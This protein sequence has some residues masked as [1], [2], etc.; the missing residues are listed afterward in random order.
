MK[1]ILIII[2]STFL[3]YS[4]AQCIVDAGPDIYVCVDK[5]G[6][7]DSSVLQASLL[8]STPYQTIKW[9]A[10]HFFGL[11][12]IPYL[13][14]SHFLDDTILF[15]PKIIFS[16]GVGNNLLL[17]F[18]I[19]LTDSLGNICI[20]STK[21]YFSK[22]AIIPDNYVEINEQ[23][24]IGL[25]SG[26]GGGIPPL[27]TIWTPNYNISD[28]IDNVIAWPMVN[29]TYY[30]VVTD[31]VGCVNTFGTGLFVKVLPFGTNLNSFF[32]E[33]FSIFPN[34]TNKIITIQ[35]IEV[36]EKYSVDL[37]SVLGEQ[38][39]SITTRKES[40]N[41]DLEKLNLNKGTYFVKIAKEQAAFVSKLIY[42]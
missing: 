20:D 32:S 5:F 26:V 6:V 35:N 36:T 22:F 41:I 11:S 39:Y 30:S 18:T 40:L 12:T 33:N 29:T 38:V 8:S 13:Y 27:T 34:P 3:I 7:T 1:H 9:E 17:N 14:S 42:K 24:T 31:S 28:T 4:K 37:Y 2:F 21:V 19:T 23:D 10:K 25:Y 15:N 16:D